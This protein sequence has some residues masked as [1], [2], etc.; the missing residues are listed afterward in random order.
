MRLNLYLPIFLLLFVVAGCAS[1]KGVQSAS[2]NADPSTEGSPFS[3]D[4]LQKRTFN[5]FW[6]TPDAHWQIPDRYPTINFSSIA[7]TGFGFTAYLIGVER[8]YITRA[9]AAE[10]T[11]KTLLALTEL[12]QGSQPTGVSGY[13]GLFY[14]FLDPYQSLRYR[15][16]ELSTIDTGLL[17]AGILSAQSYFDQ[18]DATETQIRSLADALFRRVEWDWAMGTNKNVIS[19]GWKPEHGFLDSK[20]I[21]Y[22][23]AMVLIIM[24]MGSPTHPIPE[25]GWQGWTSGYK[26]DNYRGQE[27]VDF[28]P[29]FGHQYSQMYIDF[30]GIQDDY[31]RAKGI[32]YF[33]N[34]K[35]AT[36]TNKAYCLANPKKYANYGEN[37]WGLTACDGPKDTT[38]TDA[39]GIKR[40]FSGYRARGASSKEEAD[41][42]TIAPTAVG[43][44]VPFAPDICIP[45]LQNMWTKYYSD[46]V[47]KY[48]FKDAYN[49]TF[50]FKNP[51]GW[52]DVDYLGIDEGPIVIQIENYRSKFVWNLMK[53]NPYIVAGLKKA[54]FTGGWLK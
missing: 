11:L 46:L 47:G 6:E 52:F 13:K 38:G 36:L 21:G 20:W 49:P 15:D 41:D 14:H 9:Q 34:S 45:A 17:M 23:E 27:Y 22:N 54:G 39:T 26:L 3:L 19:M 16:V 44:S 43:G 1:H 12:P 42:G 37:E 28:A 32:D 4:E 24:A 25:T 33:E 5:Y 35:R 29:L 31:M 18:N 51:R 8:H 50:T 53:K 2:R 48:G 10:R 7:A 40:R 30:K